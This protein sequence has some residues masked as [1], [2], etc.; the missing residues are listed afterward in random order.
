MK[1]ITQNIESDLSTVNA[2]LDD[3]CNRRTAISSQQDEPLKPIG[4][5]R[6]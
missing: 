2:V 5:E 6:G 3:V 4:G 1:N